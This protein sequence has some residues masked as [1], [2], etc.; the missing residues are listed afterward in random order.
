MILLILL[1]F[2]VLQLCPVMNHRARWQRP[3]NRAK[4]SDF[5]DAA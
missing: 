3:V 1:E 2:V 5:S 4:K